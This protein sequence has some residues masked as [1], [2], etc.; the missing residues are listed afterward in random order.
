MSIR[1]T[2]KNSILQE[3]KDICNFINKNKE[4]IISLKNSE[5][6]S[7]FVE[8]RVNKN[9]N[10]INNKEEKIILLRQ[11]L[12]NLENGDLD[13]EIKNE[14]KNNFELMSSKSLESKNKKINTREEDTLTLNK[15][16]KK[17]KTD[18]RFFKY[19]KKD[20]DYFL[21]FYEKTNDK[22]PNYIY[23]K[24]LD[25]PN[26]K[27]YIY[28]NIHFY[29]NKASDNSGLLTM[30]EKK[31]EEKNTLIIHE[32]SKTSYKIFK[33]EGQNRKYLFSNKIR[34]IIN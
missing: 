8:N 32:W 30:F 26:N 15:M 22:L 33:K 1:I 24:L 13:E 19:E 12:I 5:L 29:G 23:E 34:K 27:G 3:I 11:K 7:E 21:R 16:F 28:K 2:L 31:Y 10:D 14:M 9:I 4:S 18:R 25:M 17:E 20:S 6:N